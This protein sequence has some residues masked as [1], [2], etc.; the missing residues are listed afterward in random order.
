MEIWA[1]EMHSYSSYSSHS[2]SCRSSQWWVKG[3]KRGGKGMFGRVEPELPTGGG[4]EALV[5]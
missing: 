3:R 2:Y 4:G 1:A 5:A